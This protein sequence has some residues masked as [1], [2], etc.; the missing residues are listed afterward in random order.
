MSFPYTTAPKKLRAFL[1]GIPE[2][3][4]PQKVTQSYLKGIGMKSSAD[5]TIIPVLKT[6]GLLDGSG[7]PKEEYKHFRDKSKGPAIL[8]NLIRATYKDLYSTYENAHSQTDEKLR[9]FF[10]ASSTLGKSAIDFQIATFK[11]LSEFA[12]FGAVSVAKES[13]PPRGV[14][15]IPT[16]PEIHINLQIHL[17]E[18]KDA[19]IY[20]SIFQALAK[21]LLKGS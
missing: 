1:R 5:R 20:D 9:D 10:S 6:V 18:S 14:T 2:R 15:S 12:D 4:V 21:H 17:P 19:S 3:A 16:Y 11:A 8:A 7:V 13:L